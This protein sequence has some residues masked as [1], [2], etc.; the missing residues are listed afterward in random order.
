MNTRTIKQL[1]GL[2]YG[3]R[4]AITLFSAV[5][6]L[7]LLTEVILYATQVGIFEQ[8]KSA[9]DMRQKQAFHAAEA[10][11]EKA[12]EFFLANA[13][14]VSYPGSNGWLDTG[15]ATARWLPCDATLAADPNH[16]CSGETFPAG[17]FKDDHVIPGT[18]YYSF[19]DATNPQDDDT[20]LPLKTAAAD[21]DL[22]ERL[23]ALGE[24][25]EVQALLCVLDIDPNQTTPV[26]GCI[27]HGSVVAGDH[28]YFM[29]TLLAKGQSACNGGTCEGEALIAE[30][31]GSFGPA[32]GDGGPGVPLT[33]RSNFPPGGTA[34]LVPN[35][36]GGGPGVPIS[37]WI[38]GRQSPEL[39]AQQ[40]TAFD[41]SSGSWST[42]ERQEWYG[43]DEMPENYQCPT[44]T[45]SCASDEHRL[46]YPDANGQVVGID[47]VVDDQFPC[48]LFLSTFG[49]AKTVENFNELKAGIGTEISDCSILDASSKGVYWMTGDTCT[50]NSNQ[51]IGSPDFPV[52]LVSAAQHTRLNGGAKFF[53]VLF[54]TDVLHDDAVLDSQGTNTIYGAAVVDADLGSYSGTFQ[55]VYIDSIVRLASQS[56]GIGKI[57]GG[58]TDFH[59]IWEGR[60]E[61]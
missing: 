18:Y 49:Q 48:D 9:N 41:P 7:I 4:G 13:E 20:L 6:I 31:V 30:K 15:S 44:T 17:D 53:G 60:A 61:S 21:N 36:N 32:A 25:V 42:C 54:V 50:I 12:R 33:T 45:C 11:L 16:P 3:Q 22:V 23:N 35:P 5:L 51:V 43:V 38:N 57:S 1:R 55:I 27:P 56:G 40:E 19:A 47:I 24:T 58:W 2:P 10:G 8:R 28:I 39:C 46:S 26:Q 52:F 14:L 29:L 37:A 59:S 34:E